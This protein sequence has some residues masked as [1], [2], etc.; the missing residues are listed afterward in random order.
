MQKLGEIDT[1]TGRS[2]SSHMRDQYA[3]NFYQRISCLFMVVYWCPRRAASLVTKTCLSRIFIRLHLLKQ[4]Q[5][6]ISTDV[7]L[8]AC[9]VLT[10]KKTHEFPREASGRNII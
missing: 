6:S 4:K 3:M 2:K 10:Y 5:F 8:T 9:T 1:E 7:C